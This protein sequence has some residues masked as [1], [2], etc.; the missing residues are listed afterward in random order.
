MNL[1]QRQP[2]NLGMSFKPTNTQ[3]VLLSKVTADANTPP[4]STI[5]PYY[6]G[7]NGIHKATNTLCTG[8]L[9]GSLGFIVLVLLAL[10]MM[11][12]A[13]NKRRQSGVV[14]APEDQTY[15]K[16]PQTSWTSKVKKH[17]I[18]A[19][20]WSKRHHREYRLSSINFGSLPSRLHIV[21]ISFYLACNIAFLLILTWD[22]PNRYS[23][24]AD[25]RGRSGT[26]CVANMVPLVILAGRNNPLIPL[27]KIS[28]DTYNLFH[29]W[30]GRIAVA[31]IVIHFICWAIAV[32]ADGGWGLVREKI[33]GDLF[34][35]AGLAGLLC[36]LLVV[37]LSLSPIRHAFYETFL[38]IH[39]FLAAVIFTSTW[40]HCASSVVEGGLPQ[41][42][43]II[44]VVSL[45]VAERIARIARTLYFNWSGRGFT[46]A[47]C[48]AMAGESTRV[49]LQLPRLVDIKPGTHA[50]LRFWGL[51]MWESHPFSIAWTDHVDNS[52]LPV[53]E[54][55]IDRANTTTSVSFIVIAHGG[56]TR[57]LFNKAKSC[58]Q[59]LQV[60][61][62]M[63]G[64]YAGYHRLE[65]YGHAVLIAGAGG[66]TH[67][68]SYL[69]P[70]LER[71]S[72][73]TVATRRLT[74]VW[75]VREYQS[76]EW[77]RPHL[78][79]L[80]RIP[81]SEDILRV[82][83]YVTRLQSPSDII[84]ANPTVR[85]IG[86]RPNL[87]LLLAEELAEQ[88]GAMSVNVCGPGGL[89]DDVREI[90]R[91]AQGATVIDFIE[92]SFSW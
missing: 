46:T 91:Q 77:I 31:E 49:T 7:L 66:I 86:G 39:I 40:V 5:A 30:I 90:V 85:I 89:A 73:G 27:L 84:D 12:R 17:F 2:P 80:R 75:I 59:G 20:L 78:D 43:W 41:L 70:L 92:E 67:V 50:Y 83:V 81:Q 45:W 48:E 74:L 62:S 44:A 88:I 19:S 15:W 28:F 21:F 29:R 1:Y 64:P 52:G 79:A 72:V 37:L 42:P 36:M 33:S 6:T 56:V 25:L 14:S 38:D 23:V 82:K 55:K 32:V 57:R 9:W 58:P 61:A 24:V 53:L 60:R 87:S 69:R 4:E 71:A 34:I 26:L 22:N 63:E 18:Y 35:A 54:T 51:N 10:R 11:E 65:S 76:L 13:W 68:V 3:P 47:S 8:L 16:I